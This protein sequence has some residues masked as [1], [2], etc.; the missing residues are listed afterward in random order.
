MIDLSLLDT[1][2]ST[3]TITTTV[4]LRARYA[5]VR[6][7]VATTLVGAAVFG[8]S[9]AVGADQAS[10][11]KEASS[12]AAQILTQSTSLH[13]IAVEQANDTQSL[14]AAQLQ[15]QKSQAKLKVDQEILKQARANLSRA[16]VD[17]FV[18]GVDVGNLTTILTS[19]EVTNL[20]RGDFQS[21][22]TTSISDYLRAT[23]NAQE[24]ERAAALQLQAHLAQANQ[25]LTQI[26]QARAAL[27]SVINKEQTTLSSVNGQIQSLIQQAIQAK[28]R[29]T[30][31]QGLPS[32]KGVAQVATTSA[33]TSTW[34]GVPAP[35]SPAAF[36]ALRNCESGGNYS[37]DTG[38]G[39]YGAYQFSL[40]T[41]ERL[42]FSGLPSAAPPSTQDQA[43]AMLQ[44]ESGWGQW[45]AC[46]AILGLL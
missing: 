45:P 36:S 7:V 4:R 43:A 37:D 27:Q 13:T 10:L 23:Q 46:S 25:A 11:Q 38:N 15:V 20:V 35:P 9:S 30:A 2:G 8:I 5:T 40:G 41:W 44:Q 19:S 29:V 22:A 31:T 32:P 17:S 6:Y 42:G 28:A 18:S 14:Q 34:G 1:F 21:I 24:Q 33:G 39:Y 26:D 16:A 12:L 3:P